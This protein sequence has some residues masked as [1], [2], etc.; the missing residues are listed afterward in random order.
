LI[1]FA[2]AQDASA[3]RS[4]RLEKYSIL[5]GYFRQISDDED[6]KHAA[7]FAVGRAFPATD[8]R[9]L[10]VGGAIVSQTI[11]RLLE[12]DPRIF[13]DTV[14]AKGDVGE[15]LRALWNLKPARHSRADESSALPPSYQPPLSLREIAAAFDD[16]ACSG[17][18]QHKRQLL[19]DLFSRCADPREAAYLARIIFHDLRSGVQEPAMDQ[20]IAQAFERPPADVRRAQFLIGDVG[21]TAALAKR[22]QL[23]S[24]RLVLFHPIQFMLA[25]AQ[26]TPADAAQTLDGRTFFAE[27]KFDG[28]RAQFHKQ[29]DRIAIYT[30]TMDRADQ[31]FPDLVQSMRQI[32]GDVLLDGEIVPWQNG[33]VLPFAH[34][35]RRLGRKA[36]T[37]RLLRDNPLAFVAFDLLY[38]DGQLLVD[39]PLEARRDELARLRV[40]SPEGAFLI[41]EIG[42]VSTADQI[43]RA[44]VGA[45]EK[46]NEGLVLKDPSSRYVPGRRGRAWL[47]L[48]GHLPTLDCVVTFAETG[49]GKRRNS[50][51]DY[52]FAVW[53]RDPADEGAKLLNVGKAFIGVTDEEIAQLT[54]IFTRTT[55]Q[56]FGRVRQ[57]QPQVVL[58]IACDQIQK[59]TRHASG[60]ALRFPR[61]KRIRWDKRPQDADRLE[62]VIE[63][64]QSPSNF[65]RA[66]DSPAA[67]EEEPTLFDGLEEA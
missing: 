31:S 67:Q 7:R 48:K 37:P 62:R 45:R 6:L 17:N 2:I 11:V 34:I 13:H 39:Q 47:K 15:A 5:A 55:V 9:T 38:R 56:Q 18:T 49:H 23:G 66:I 22:N 10:S 46:G 12:I 36:L 21:E 14:V 43:E 54:D 53:D 44:F 8:E 61:I 24:A 16:L 58:E 32:P 30:R 64:Y 51:S 25:T 41:S 19:F 4:S 59:S 63:L 33:R 60:Y 29:S 42:T 3:A 26:E 28:I 65:G 52:T 1:E 57:V 35:Q 40:Q 50:L 27:N 20:V